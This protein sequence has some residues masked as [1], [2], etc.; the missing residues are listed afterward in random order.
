MNKYPHRTF[1]F[2]DGIHYDGAK[3]AS[4]SIFPTHDEDVLN[5]V[6]VCALELHE[7]KQF[8]NTHSF[9]LQ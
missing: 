5:E 2:F 4:Q 1:V 6:V 8:T 3:K 9:T 7:A